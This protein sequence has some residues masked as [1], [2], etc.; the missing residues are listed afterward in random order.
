MSN[1][2]LSLLEDH[3]IPFVLGGS[4][5]HVRQ[6]WVGV[7]CPTCS[8]GTLKFKLGINLEHYFMTC[9]SCGSK[10]FSEGLEELTQ[11]PRKECIKLSILL[12]DKVEEGLYKDF[13]VKR[14]K[15]ILPKD[16]G[17]LLPQHISYLKTRKLDPDTLTRLWGVQGIGTAPKLSWRLFIPIKLH[18]Q[19]VSWTTRSISN[20]SHIKRYDS[21]P[22][23]CESINCHSLL[24]GEDYARHSVIV[25]EGPFDVFRIGPG[26]VATLGV[27]FSSTQVS[28]ISKYPQR[29]ICFDNEPIAQQQAEK[30]AGELKVYPGQTHVVILDAKD[31]GSADDKEVRKLRQLFLGDL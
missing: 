26:A 31:P 23:E 9:W 29:C 6:G 22:A 21:A 24:F 5:R 14:G 16:L 7:D 27:K 30:L 13:P 4:H 10:R 2:L 18:S 12:K 19:T 8:P 1:E 3:N 15:L 28:R 25:V 17:P 11:L 20:E